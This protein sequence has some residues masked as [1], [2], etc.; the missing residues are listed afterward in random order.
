MRVFE[1][2]SHQITV[3]VQGRQTLIGTFPV[4]IEPH[5]FARLARSNARSPL[6]K[7]LVTSLDGRR[8][9]HAA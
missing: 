3:S 6:V 5:A 9:R 1:A 4:G 2:E 8:A 7:T